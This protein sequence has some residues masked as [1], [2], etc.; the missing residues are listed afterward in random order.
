[1]PLA[2]QRLAVDHWPIEV[3]LDDSMAMIPSARLSQFD[4]W[5][6]TARLSED[7]DA[8]PGPGDLQA[9]KTIDASSSGDR[10]DLVID[11]VLQ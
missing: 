9:Q 5:V 2:V 11:Q 8:I 6:L 10:V 7:G 4:R 1:M 3:R